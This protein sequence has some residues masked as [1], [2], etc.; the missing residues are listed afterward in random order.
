MSD[1][2][3][4]TSTNELDWDVSERDP[5]DSSS[6]RVD[7]AFPTGVLLGSAPSESCSRTVSPLSGVDVDVAGGGGENTETGDCFTGIAP[8]VGV[9]ASIEVLLFGISVVG[10]GLKTETV[11]VPCGDGDFCFSGSLSPT[12]SNSSNDFLGA[13]R[14]LRL[15][16]EEPLNALKPPELENVGVDGFGALGVPTTDFELP[17]NGVAEPKMDLFPKAVGEPN[18]GIP[19]VVDEADGDEGA[20]LPNAD[21]GG[22]FCCVP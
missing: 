16:V 15:T 10:G 2:A 17:P 13:A 12:F 5:N 6:E 19:N 18:A 4:L 20:G 21:T 9:E 1:A 3:L 7:G 8:G 14:E 22:V 11:D